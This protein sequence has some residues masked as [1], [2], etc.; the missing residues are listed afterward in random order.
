MLYDYEFTSNIRRNIRR[1]L[2]N[3]RH[4]MNEDVHCLSTRSEHLS[5]HQEVT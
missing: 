2:L 3:L 5:K 1:I 4:K